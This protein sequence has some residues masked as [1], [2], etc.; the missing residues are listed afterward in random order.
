MVSYE[1]LWELVAKY[2]YGKIRKA[3]GVIFLHFSPALGGLGG[4]SSV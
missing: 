3:G 4:G 1:N 2:G